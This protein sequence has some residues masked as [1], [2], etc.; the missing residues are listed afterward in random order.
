MTKQPAKRRNAV[1]A[2]ATGALLLVGGSTYALWSATDGAAGGSITAGNLDLAAIASNAWDV[3]SDR[4][5][6]T[7]TVTTEASAADSVTAI[8]L[9][10]APQGHAIADLADWQIVPGDTVALT[11]PYKLTLLGDNLVA[12]LTM[13]G[14][15]TLL[16]GSTFSQTAPSA[17]TLEYQLFDGSGDAVT[18]RAELPTADFLAGSYKAGSGD[19]E[20]VVF[21]LY[22]T[23]ES[24]QADQAQIDTGAVLALGTSVTATL[25]Q[26][27][28]G[29]APGDDFAGCKS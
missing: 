12:S 7:D 14:A 1:I 21:V 24:Q 20:I 27:R 11:F 13:A 29:A 8:A 17:L 19:P 15:D 9:T 10:G 22:I 6:Q 23:F 26:V 25:Q 28:C 3:S 16:A 4:T 5:D 2:A 18:T